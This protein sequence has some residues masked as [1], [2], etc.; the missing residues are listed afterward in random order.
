MWF[1]ASCVDLHGL[2][3]GQVQRNLTFLAVDGMFLVEGFGGWVEA[4]A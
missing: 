1:G 3:S 2:N 4:L